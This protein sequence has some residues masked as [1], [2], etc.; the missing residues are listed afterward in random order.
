MANREIGEDEVASLGWSVEIGHAG[1]GNSS[2]NGRV[3]RGRCLNTTVGKWAGMFQAGVEEEVGVVVE[4]NI[5]ALF[6]TGAFNNAQFDN[7]RR[8]DRSAVAVSLHSGSAGS[9]PL[10]LLQD[11]H[12]VPEAAVSTSDAVDAGNGVPQGV[13]RDSGRSRHGVVGLRWKMRMKE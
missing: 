8:I 10:R 13:R 2:Q 7:G 6:H 1:G 12:L 11:S 9:S 3:V 5:L 4:S